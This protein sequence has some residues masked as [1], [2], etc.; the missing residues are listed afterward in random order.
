ML[1][2]I[3]LFVGLMLVG[4]TISIQ[5]DFSAFESQ[6]LIDSYQIDKSGLHT[7]Y[8]Q[9]LPPSANKE[10]SADRQLEQSG[11]TSFRLLTN[12]SSFRIIHANQL[13]HQLLIK[14]DA[15][16]LLLLSQHEKA[17]F[18]LYELCKLLI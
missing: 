9:L 5:L 13:T 8:E 17:G 2:L 4:L 1:K 6:Q 7:C 10:E 11:S 14:L 12:D 16:S 15:N 18:Y 3:R